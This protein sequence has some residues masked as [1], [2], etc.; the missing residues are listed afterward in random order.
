MEELGLR[1]RAANAVVSYVGYIAKMF[2]PTRLAVLYPHP[3]AAIPVIAVASCGLALVVLTVVFLWLGR[4][5]G[6][7]AVGWL[8][9]VGTLVPV[10]GLVQAGVQSMA[11][12]YT[13]V[14]M[15]GLVIIIAWWVRE[16]V[17]RHRGLR[18]AAATA[19]VAVLIACAICTRQQLRYWRNS[20]SLFE[21]TLAITSNNWLIH[22]NYANVL[23]EEERYEEAIV[24]FQEALRIRPNSAEIYSNLGGALGRAGRAEEEIECYRKAL[25]LKGDFAVGHYN[26]AA[27]LSRQ[28]KRD[29]AIAEY[30]KAIEL[31]PD[32]ADALSNLGFELAEKGEYEQALEYYKKAIEIEPGHI[33]AHG[34]MALVLAGLDRIDEA[35]QECRIV[36]RARPDDAEMHFNV[37]VLLERQGKTAEA[38]E[39]YRQAM[40]LNPADGRA[41]E[42]LKALRAK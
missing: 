15:T 23:K 4:K 32:Y 33:I 13:Y 41:S 26:L 28:G 24:H 16:I 11:D 25:K 6:Y 27:A 10:I 34:R 18:V 42:R 12:R 36:L 14:P 21:H 22:N 37:G 38:A 20:E 39:S 5:R 17:E 8:W 3:V 40:K 9:Y 1:A 2:W 29:E 7:L 30:R 31:Q 19:A 35:I